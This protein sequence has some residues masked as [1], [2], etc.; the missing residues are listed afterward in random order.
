MSF[1]KLFLIASQNG[2]ALNMVWGANDSA[3]IKSPANAGGLGTPTSVTNFGR[4]AVALGRAHLVLLYDAGFTGNPDGSA[5]HWYPVQAKGANGAG[6]SD[7]TAPGAPMSVWKEVQR[8]GA[9]PRMISSAVVAGGTF[10]MSYDYGLDSVYRWGSDWGAGTGVKTVAATNGS[11]LEITSPKEGDT[12]PVTLTSVAVAWRQWAKDGTNTVGST[13]ASITCIDTN[14]C[15]IS[16]AQNGLNATV[17]VVRRTQGVIAT[18]VLKTINR[19]QGQLLSFLLHVPYSADSVT[20]HLW[21]LRNPGRLLGVS[22][23]GSLGVGNF[24]ITPTWT[25]S[26]GTGLVI[27]DGS[28]G[29][30]TLFRFHG[31][32]IWDSLVVTRF[33]L[34]SFINGTLVSASI[35]TGGPDSIAVQLPGSGLVHASIA[36]PGSNGLNVPMARNW[37]LSDSG[38]SSVAFWNEDTNGVPVF[39]TA[40]RYTILLKF[41]AVANGFT[42]TGLSCF[43]WSGSNST[44]VNP[45]L[46][47]LPT[48][49]VLGQSTCS[50]T[51]SMSN[52]AGL[53]TF[54]GQWPIAAGLTDWPIPLG[55]PGILNQGSVKTWGF[56]VGV[57]NSYGLSNNSTRTFEVIP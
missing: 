9:T 32:T 21:P 34:D 5:T 48:A 19:S 12:I 4:A 15:P 14:S 8:P 49:Q 36:W 55:Q 52:L 7:P 33:G 16:I 24:A 53:N 56:S 46:S 44:R 38:R 20:M 18:P 3:Q 45:F 13:T 29:I 35:P 17:H 27:P 40:S 25:D 54:V 57:P 41:Q 11:V 51:W 37:L 2:M 1:A 42:L 10:S 47:E 43:N 6:Q 39:D 26:A 50:L 30:T 23:L 31:R 22:K 28:Y